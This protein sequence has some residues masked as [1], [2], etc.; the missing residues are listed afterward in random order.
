M[1]TVVRDRAVGGYAEMAGRLDGIDVG[2]EEKKLPSVFFFLPLHHPLHPV[3][4]IAAA[5]I[6]QAVGR[7]HE[8]RLLRPV[9]LPGVLMDIADVADRTADRIQQRG[10]AA[11]IVLFF[12]HLRHLLQRNSVIQHLTRVIEKHGGYQHL[13][14]GLKLLPEHAVVAADGVAL[15][16]AHRAAP[17]QDHN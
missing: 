6:L 16:A 8:D 1:V 13:P 7:D 2:S 3:V 11:H 12:S 9:L 10:A 5:R 17:V 4:G 15:Q 14:F